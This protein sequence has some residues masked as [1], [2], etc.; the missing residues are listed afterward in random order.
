MNGKWIIKSGSDF[1]EFSLIELALDL[2]NKPVV[3]S[4]GK[5]VVNSKIEEDKEFKEIVDE[6]YGTLKAFLIININ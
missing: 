6:F 3:S 2:K 4:I 5:Y 1:K